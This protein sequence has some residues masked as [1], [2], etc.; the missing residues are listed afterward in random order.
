MTKK[1]LIKKIA[2]THKTSINKIEEFYN[3]FEKV[4]IEAIATNEEVILSPFI[5][6]FILKTSLE[7]RIPEIKFIINQDGEKTGIK[8]GRSITCPQTTVV[9][10][11]IS[12]T[13]KQKVKHLDLK[14]E[15]KK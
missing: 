6:R 2:E 9:K 15:F 10:F 4:L 8:T 13:L 7:R 1:E 11:K 12:D 3:S 14:E 5:G